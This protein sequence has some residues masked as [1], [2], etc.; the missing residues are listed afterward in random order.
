MAKILITDDSSFMRNLL[1]DILIEEGHEVFHA[2]DGQEMLEK[3]D[4]IQP[5]LVLLD[6]VMPIMDGIS[7][8]EELKSRNPNA[9]IVM[10]TAQGQWF[11][12]EEAFAKGASAYIEKPFGAKEVLLVIREVLG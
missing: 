10:C 12:K 1:D 6:I 8:I 5:D 3:F 9:K 7:A 2:A 4:E 11:K